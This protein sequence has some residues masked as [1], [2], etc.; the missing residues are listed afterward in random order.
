MVPLIWRRNY[1]G[2]HHLHQFEEMLIRVGL[3]NFGELSRSATNSGLASLPF[4]FML[5]TQVGSSLCTNMGFSDA[6]KRLLWHRPNHLSAAGSVSRGRP[7][8]RSMACR[9][10]S[11]P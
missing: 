3:S 5:M 10:T 8:S 11:T 4:M 6:F 1:R 7:S 2:L 9:G